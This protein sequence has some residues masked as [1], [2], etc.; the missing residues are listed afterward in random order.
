[1]GGLYSVGRFS[2]CLRRAMLKECKNEVT[3]YEEILDTRY[4]ILL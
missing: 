1:M 2:A 4:R 3:N